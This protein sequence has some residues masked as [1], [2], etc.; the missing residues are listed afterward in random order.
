MSVRTRLAAGALLVGSL[1]GAYWSLHETGALATILDTDALHASVV[2]L[3]PWGPAAVVGLMVLAILVSPIPSAPIALAAGAAYGH[4]WG[5]LYVLLG[6]GAGAMAAFGVARFV[7]HEAVHRWFGGRLSVGLIGSENGLMGIVFV[8]RLLPF[9]SFD[10]VSYAAGLTVLSFWRF[11]IATLAGLGQGSRAAAIGD[12]RRQAEDEGAHEQ[13]HA[14]QR[15]TC[16]SRTR[17]FEFGAVGP[18]RKRGSWCDAGGASIGRV[19]LGFDGHRL[20]VGICLHHLAQRLHLLAIVG[21]TGAHHEVRAQRYLLAQPQGALHL[22]RADL[23]RFP[24]TQH[25]D[26]SGRPQPLSMQPRNFN[27]A[28]CRMT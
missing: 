22:G 21:A 20:A 11:A 8:S 7:G 19:Q 9:L 25:V 6:A 12:L 27:L 14:R 2:Q 5:A 26:P 16:L 17:D 10:I 28:R 23:G 13:P 24:A 1:A 3:G 4:G 18:G 15:Q